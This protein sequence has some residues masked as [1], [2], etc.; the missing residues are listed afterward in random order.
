MSCI[1]PMEMKIKSQYKGIQTI[2]VDCRHCLNCL[3]KRQSQI[4]FLA[5]KELLSVYQS[6]RSASFVTLTYDDNHIPS[7]YAYSLSSS[8]NPYVVML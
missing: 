3:V 2:K 8:V 1:N 5:K 4:E 7:V 6:G